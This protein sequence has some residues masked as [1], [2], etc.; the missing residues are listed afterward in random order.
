[1]MNGRA[2]DPVGNDR[3]DLLCIVCWRC[4]PSCNRFFCR[5]AVLGLRRL[6]WFAVTRMSGGP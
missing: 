3:L 1:M 4:W 5:C 2:G 6:S